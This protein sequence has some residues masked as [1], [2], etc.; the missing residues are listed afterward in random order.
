MRAVFFFS[1]FLP[2]LFSLVVF[3]GGS[4]VGVGQGGMTG[5]ELKKQ[6]WLSVAAAVVLFFSTS[7]RAR[8]FLF[9][10]VISPP[11]SL[12][13]S[14]GGGF[15]GLGQTGPRWAGMRTGI[16]DGR[17]RRSDG[18]HGEG[19]PKGRQDVRRTPWGGVE[20]GGSPTRETVRVWWQRLERGR[21]GSPCTYTT[22]YSSVRSFAV[23]VRTIHVCVVCLLVSSSLAM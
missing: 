9:S 22:R 19:R 7:Q 18:Q 17:E 3:L 21:E 1:V 8:L 5:S 11:F 23:R 14:L 16:N 2:S 6:G 10:L 4:R 12:L 15:F 13:F 20:G